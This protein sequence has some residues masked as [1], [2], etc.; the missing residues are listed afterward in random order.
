MRSKHK[1]LIEQLD[2]KLSVFMEAKSVVVPERGWVHTVRTTFNMTMDQLG[3]KLGITRQGVKRIEDS[4]SNGSITLNSLKEVAHAMDLQL[5]YALVP[6]NGTIDGLIERKVHQL[7]TKIILRTNQNM[8]LEDQGI[9]G[10]KL[11]VAINELSAE[12]KRE[13]RK[14]LW[15]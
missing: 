4:E 3:K 12:I 9:G 8:E 1:L 6:K 10:N 14:S 15:D 2:K 5:V 7:A 11:E 13:L